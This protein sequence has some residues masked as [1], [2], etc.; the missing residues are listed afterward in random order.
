MYFESQTRFGDIP[1]PREGSAV[2]LLD[3]RQAIADGVRT[4]IKYFSRTAHGSITVLPHSKP[5]E[6]HLP[7]LVGKLIKTVQRSAD[8]LIIGS[9]TLTAAVAWTAVPGGPGRL[10]VCRGPSRRARRLPRTW[11][12]RTGRRR[13]PGHRRCAQPRK[14]AGIL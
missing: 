12:A 6:K 9:A 7:L 5:F 1:R 3:S 4:A 11:S 2:T 13:S 8:R 10:Q 14:A